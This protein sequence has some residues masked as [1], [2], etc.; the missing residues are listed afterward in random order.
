MKGK[1][2]TPSKVE[3]QNRENQNVNSKTW[4]DFYLSAPLSIF[5]L[6]FKNILTMILYTTNLKDKWVLWSIPSKVE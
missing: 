4:F 5:V 1:W 2:R 6:S 3:F